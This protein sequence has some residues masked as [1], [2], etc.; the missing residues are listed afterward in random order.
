MATVAATIRSVLSQV[1]VAVEY[2]VIDGGSSDGT[3]DAV[4]PFRGAL[5]AFVSERDAGLYDAMNKGLDRATGDFV[6]FMNAGDQFAGDRALCSAARGMTDRNRCY[7]ARAR[8]SGAGVEYDTP[9]AGSRAAAW[10]GHG[11]PSHQATFYPRAF[12]AAARY[13]L[14]L[15]SVA[16]TDFTFRAF[17]TCGF[18]YVDTLVANFELGGVSNRFANFSQSR[19]TAR[20]RERL[21]GRHRKWF[22]CGFAVVYCAGPLV[23]WFVQR[24]FSPALL[25]TLRNLKSARTAARTKMNGAK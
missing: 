24:L 20:A 5:A 12:A 3:A 6:C 25:A 11:I 9:P 18:E 14:A 19:R 4:A 10:I 16:D 13:D 7:F 22:S 8:V 23:G 21:V 17:D 1:G 2:I 15:G